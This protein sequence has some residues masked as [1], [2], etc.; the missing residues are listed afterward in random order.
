VAPD[1]CCSPSTFSSTLVG[2]AGRWGALAAAAGF[3]SG[4]CAST[5][6]PPGGSTGGSLGGGRRGRRV[7]RLGRQGALP[8][9]S[10]HTAGSIRIRSAAAC[11]HPRLN[12]LGA[13][14]GLGPAFVT[15]TLFWAG[16]GGD[17][18]DGGIRQDFPRLPAG[19]PASSEALLQNIL[20]LPGSPADGAVQFVRPAEICSPRAR[21]GGASSSGA[22]KHRS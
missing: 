21:F 15:R 20:L 17:G 18:V 6:R 2:E 10:P 22:A 14:G 4:R 13:A 7:D 16:G 19:F 1:C 9:G 11:R 5:P 12:G 8:S 3:A